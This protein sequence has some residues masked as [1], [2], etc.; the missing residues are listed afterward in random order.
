MFWLMLLRAFAIGPLLGALGLS[1]REPEF[2]IASVSLLIILGITNVMAQRKNAL[3]K[4]NDAL[5]EIERLLY[6]EPLDN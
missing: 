2:Y 3:S 5:S 1:W 6:T 4:E